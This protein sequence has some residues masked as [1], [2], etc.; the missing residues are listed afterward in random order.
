M[1]AVLWADMAQ[2]I[3]MVAGLV[4]VLVRGCM[5]VGGLGEVW[6]IA[7]EDDRFNLK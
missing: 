5:L 7:N 6:R 3:V 4:A 2:T 1:K